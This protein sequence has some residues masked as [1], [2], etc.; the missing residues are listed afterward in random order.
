MIRPTTGWVARW[1]E[2][3][4]RVRK[5]RVKIP[6]LAYPFSSLLRPQAI[7]EWDGGVRGL[8]KIDGIRD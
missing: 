6:C 3:P 8:V 7:I 2:R 4:S 1:L 5:S